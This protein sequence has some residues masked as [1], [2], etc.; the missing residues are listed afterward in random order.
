M[1]RALW[2]PERGVHSEDKSARSTPP[3]LLSILKKPVKAHPYGYWSDGF[4]LV[5]TTAS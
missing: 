1:G 4:L 5:Q 2:K 3:P